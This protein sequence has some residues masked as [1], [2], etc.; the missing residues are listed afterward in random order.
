MIVIQEENFYDMFP[1]SVELREHNFEDNPLPIKDLKLDLDITRYKI[2]AQQGVL[3]IVTARDEGKL[4]GYYSSIVQ[5]HI[6]FA[7]I[8]FGMADAY[9]VHRAYRGKGIGARMF[10]H[11]EKL[12]R[13]KGAKVGLVGTREKSTALF[14]AGWIPSEYRYVKLIGDLHD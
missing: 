5:P 12:W 9:V 10:A 11:V 14:K 1:E 2:L 7:T 3:V 6:H 4:I 8:P 13:D